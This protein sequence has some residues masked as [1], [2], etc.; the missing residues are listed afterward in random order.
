[1][2]NVPK[3]PFPKLHRV[4]LHHPD[5]SVDHPSQ[6]LNLQPWIDLFYVQ[7]RDYLSTRWHLDE[8]QMCT[9]WTQEQARA[10]TANYFIDYLNEA[11]VWADNTEEA[12]LYLSDQ[13]Y[14]IY[15]ALASDQQQRVQEHLRS[16]E[17][18]QPVLE[19]FIYD[20]DPGIIDILIGRDNN[21]LFDR[22]DLLIQEKVQEL[23]RANPWWM[24]SVRVYDTNVIIESVGDYRI[25]VFYEKWEDGEW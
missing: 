11:M 17:V 2:E 15:H 1:M 23:T 6:L 10:W 12:T 22:V 21:H 19:S 13:L 20:R 25:L 8:E 9:W 7:I 16:L 4:P 18:D 14:K 3:H 24:W 5:P